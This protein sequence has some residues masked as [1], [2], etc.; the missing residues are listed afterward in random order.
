[1]VSLLV[2]QLQLLQHID[3]DFIKFID[4]TQCPYRHNTTYKL[5]TEPSYLILYDG[6]N[7]NMITLL[8]DKSCGKSIFAIL[9]S[10]IIFDQFII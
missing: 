10:F 8:K 2:I 7:V 9:I 6:I 3:M 5:N 1:M 4:N